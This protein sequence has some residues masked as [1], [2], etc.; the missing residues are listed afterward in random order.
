MSAPKTYKC[1]WC[2]ETVRVKAAFSLGQCSEC[3]APLSCRDCDNPLSPGDN[4]ELE[5][6]APCLEEW[7]AAAPEREAEEQREEK[8]RKTKTDPYRE[9]AI[10]QHVFGL[11]EGDL[12]QY[13]PQ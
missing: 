12:A 6:C 2:G 3:K 1:A 7:D 11:D 10:A 5:T 4:L 13:E 8:A 9:I